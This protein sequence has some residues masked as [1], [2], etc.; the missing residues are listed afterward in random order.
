MSAGICIVSLGAEVGSN[1]S[2]A[3]LDEAEDAGDGVS[4]LLSDK[5]F[6]LFSSFLCSFSSW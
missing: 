2:E 3:G 5:I 6:L 1:L 4:S